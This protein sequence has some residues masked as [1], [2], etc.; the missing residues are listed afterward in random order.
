[1]FKGTMSQLPRCDGKSIVRC[2]FNYVDTSNTGLVTLLDFTTFAVK[3]LKLCSVNSDV[4][5][6]HFHAIDCDGSGGLD[7]DEF[8]EFLAD[9]ICQAEAE[10]K[11]EH[12]VEQQ[13]GQEY[14]SNLTLETS[15]K[16]Y[17]KQ[18]VMAH[19]KAAAEA[20]ARADGKRPFCPTQIPCDGAGLLDRQ[21]L[22]I[23]HLRKSVDPDA[24]AVLEFWFPPCLTDG[25]MLWFGKSPALDEEIRSRFGGLVDLAAAGEL[26]WWTADPC[27]NLALTILLDQF[28]RNMFRH[29]KRMYAT[30]AKAQAVCMKAVYHNF[31]RTITPLQ[32]IFM[33]CLVLTHSELF[34]HQELCVD[35][36]CHL[37]QHTLPQDDQLRIFGM[38]FLNHL[39]VIAKFGRFPHRNEIMGRES[40]AE[41][42]RFLNDKSFRFDLPLKYSDDGKVVF[43]ETADFVANKDG[44]APAAP[45]EKVYEAHE[46]SA[47]LRQNL[48]HTM[49]KWKKTLDQDF[50]EADKVI[51]D[52][53]K[54]NAEVVNAAAE[55]CK[56]EE[57]CPELRFDS[58]KKA[59]GGG[60]KA[61][62]PAAA[63]APAPAWKRANNVERN[64]RR[65]QMANFLSGAS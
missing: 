17:V 55:T 29:Q 24:K 30:D 1:L 19:R 45:V 62:A 7:Y 56:S 60:A 41:E 6:D 33:P 44:N 51:G 48:L 28:P 49:Q 54:K 50:P 13:Q 47:E 43:E 22:A 12:K 11:N 52:K 31:H 53:C 15:L 65:K 38:I 14:A 3:E 2:I 42:I 18:Q 5:R 36:W 21:R 32:A 37:I 4:L 8:E 59:G 9:F 58:A 40:T 35:I 61:S 23:D 27:E 46:D 34:Q 57:E 63:P 16:I 10:D 64:T 25:M 39:K 26:D 20:T